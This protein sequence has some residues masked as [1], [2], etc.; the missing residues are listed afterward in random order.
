VTL[1]IPAPVTGA[2]A[3][4]G[5]AEQLMLAAHAAMARDG[6]TSILASAAQARRAKADGEL[7]A[8]FAVEGAHLVGFDL[9][10]LSAWRT[11]GLRLVGPA[12]LVPNVACQP[13]SLPARADAPLTAYGR[14]LV[15]AISERGLVLDLA[16]MNRRGF[17]ECLQIH[18][19]PVLVSHTG[20]ARA[21]PLW[22][23]VTDDQARAIADRG[24]V[25]GVILYPAFLRGSLRG[26]IADVVAHVNAARDAVGVD[27]IAIG[28]DFDGGITLPREMRDAGD[29]VVLTQALLSAGYTPEETIGI[30]GGNALALLE[31]AFG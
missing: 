18:Q 30:L 1:G 3:G 2:I 19:G 13:S 31:R 14:S 25:I 4:P 10:V 11:L 21:R 5:V 24:G 26:G 22:R 12:H 27:H 23:N 6:R 16:H 7:K 20:L 15:E 8:I 29:L 9:A 28:T 17:D